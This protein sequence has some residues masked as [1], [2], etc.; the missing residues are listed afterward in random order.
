MLPV[1]YGKSVFSIV[2][3]SVDSRKIG[4][5]EV[6]IFLS[7]FWDRYDVGWFPHL[8]NDVCV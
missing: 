8:R 2:L 5:Y 4:L 6:P 1:M 3:A 7:L